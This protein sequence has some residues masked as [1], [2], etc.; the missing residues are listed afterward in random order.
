[1][2]PKESFYNATDLI[3]DLIKKGKKV[4]SYPL[5]GYWLDIGKHDDYEKAQ[6][7]IKNLNF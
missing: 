4:V 2:I 3:D 7:D 1:L 5:V 6:Q